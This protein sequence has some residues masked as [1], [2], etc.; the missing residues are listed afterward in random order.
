[1]TD[2]RAIERTYLDSQ[3]KAHGLVEQDIQPDGHCLFS[4]VADQLRT[5]G[6]VSSPLA[7]TSS[8]SSTATRTAAGLGAGGNGEGGGGGGEA[9]PG[10]KATRRAA[11]DYMLSH[12][13]DFEP[14]LAIDERPAAVGGFE[15][16]IDKMRNTAEWGG[17]LELAAL[18]NVYGVEIRVVQDGRTETIAPNNGAAGG[19]KTKDGAK[20][21]IWLAYYRHGYGLGEHY[22]SLRP[23]S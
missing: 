16:Y 12:R 17:Q 18:A 1:M 5:R 9:E 10:Y 20:R 23:A 6:Y 8:S 4:A 14:F 7:S 15:G 22:N 11:T 2:H 3:F 19:D 21:T 13:D